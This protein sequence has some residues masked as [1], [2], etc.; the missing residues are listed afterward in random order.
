MTHA[1][2]VRKFGGSLGVILP[3]SVSDALKITEGDEVF[4]TE[5]AEG[6]A[7]TPYDPEFEAALQDAREFMKT[8]RN[9]FR[10]LAR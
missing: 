7:I 10:A 4:V 1:L 8:H 2:K 9:A 5:T 6:L 3:K